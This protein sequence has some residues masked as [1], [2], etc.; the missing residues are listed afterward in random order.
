M[1]CGCCIGIDCADHGNWQLNLLQRMEE[2]TMSHSI[3]D[4]INVPRTLTLEFLA[5]FARFEFALKKAGYVR[6]NESQ[7][8]PDWD[9]FAR[10]VSGLDPATLA[11]TIRCCTY[12]QAHPPRKQVLIDGRLQ[13]VCVQEGR[14][15]KLKIYFWTFEQYEIMSSTAESF[16]T[17]RS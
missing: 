8:F 17:G 15:P 12:L 7:I 14:A 3:F 10:D 13:W 4:L 1:R 2:G 9:S 16:R 6:G 5:T 11:A